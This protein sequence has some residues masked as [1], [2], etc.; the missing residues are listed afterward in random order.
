MTEAETI[1]LLR[2]L[3]G[4]PG[5]QQDLANVAQAIDKIGSATEKAAG[6]IKSALPAWSQMGA[7][8]SS[9]GG[10]A[11]GAAGDTPIT[12]RR[13]AAHAAFGGIPLQ[14]SGG[15]IGSHLG[16]VKSAGA[17]LASTFEKAGISGKA[18]LGIMDKHKS[19]AGVLSAGYQGLTAAM[20]AYQLITELTT[21]AALALDIALDANPVMLVV[22]AVVA[23]TVAFATAYK[24]VTWFRNGVDAVVGFLTKHW[25]LFLVVLTGGIGLAIIL[26]IKHFGKIKSAVSAVIDFVRKHWRAI[27]AVITGPIGL[28]VAFV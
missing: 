10:R 9:L 19:T 17:G 23:L 8:V 7:G 24:K 5:F 21:V 28:A 11:G 1:N 14:G 6:R 27:L 25:K 2:E 15:D 12:K 16:G 18:L 4:S 22:L 13:L 26:V 3:R 20:Q